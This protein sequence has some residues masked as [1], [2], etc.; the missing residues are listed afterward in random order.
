MPFEGDHA[1][2]IGIETVDGPV[3]VFDSE[4]GQIKPASAIFE[5]GVAFFGQ[6][7]DGDQALAERCTRKNMRALPYW[8]AHPF[9][10]LEGEQATDEEFGA[11]MAKIM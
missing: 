6:Y 11:V 4:N 3:C 9:A 8:Q 5:G 10:Q 7:T 2:D 1:K